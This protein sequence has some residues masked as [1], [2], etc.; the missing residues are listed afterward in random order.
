M[1]VGTLPS[2]LLAT[3]L[4]SRLIGCG[5]AGTRSIATP[6]SAA[7]TGTLRAKGEAAAK[8]SFILGSSSYLVVDHEGWVAPAIQHVEDVARSLC[9]HAG[10]AFLGAGGV[11][12]AD[13]DIGEGIERVRRVRRLDLQ[14]V[15]AD[16]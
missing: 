16:A 2:G 1:A 9:G 10:E 15:E 4:R 7:D 12:R 6:S 11:V 8:K 14:H 3:T 13:D 5:A